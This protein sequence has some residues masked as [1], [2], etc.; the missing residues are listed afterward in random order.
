M[1]ISL[2]TAVTKKY[3][4]CKYKEEE[5]R[6]QIVEERKNFIDDCCPMCSRPW[7]QF[8]FYSFFSK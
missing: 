7:L 5:K 1:F 8:F 2:D 6:H 3:V 4:C